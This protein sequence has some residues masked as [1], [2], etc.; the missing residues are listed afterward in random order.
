MHWLN[1][2]I[3]GVWPEHDLVLFLVSSGCCPLL[4]VALTFPH[5]NRNLFVTDWN[6]KH[7]PIIKN[8]ILLTSGKSK[9]SRFVS[10]DDTASVSVVIFSCEHHTLYKT[11]TRRSLWLVNRQFQHWQHSQEQHIDTLNLIL[12]NKQ[13]YIF[14]YFILNSSQIPGYQCVVYQRVESWADTSSWTHLLNPQSW[15][16]LR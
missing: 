3:S 5:L 9:K 11:G 10:A 6:L 12:K 16:F 14:M 8:E 1:V 2:S 13:S 7:H 15:C 4:G